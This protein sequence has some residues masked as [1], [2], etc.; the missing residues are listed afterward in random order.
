MSAIETSGLRPGPARNIIEGTIIGVVLTA[1]SYYVGIKAGWEAKLNWLEVFA[2]FTSYLC[3]W[4]C[5]TERRIN[6]PIGAIS[7]ASLCVLFWRQGLLASAVL[8]AYLTPSLLYGWIRWKKDR[9]TRSV[10][11]LGLK[12]IPAYAL[13]T[14][15]AYFG[16]VEILHHFGAK[17]LI[18]DAIVLVGSILAQFMLDNKILENWWVWFVV[19]VVAII[20]YFQ[21]GLY[22]VAF[23]FVFFLANCL[24]GWFYWNKSRKAVTVDGDRVRTNDGLAPNEGPLALSAVRS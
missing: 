7:T 15:A 23:Q 18:L 11:H 19:D 21:A 13:A 5:N 14:A 9:E 8:N 12:W 17:I 4:L 3:T 10:R 2:V 22:L 16:A 1:L 24:V 20:D 6:Y